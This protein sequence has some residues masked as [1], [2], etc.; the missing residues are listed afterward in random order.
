MSSFLYS[1]PSPALAQAQTVKSDY[2]LENLGLTNLHRTYW[3]LPAESLY[4][5]VIFRGEGK[6]TRHGPMAVN[7]GRHT[8]RSAND[9]FIVRE[10]SSEHN[11]WW[12]DYNRPFDG[13]KFS[14]LLGRMQAFLQGR[15][16]FVQDCYANADPQYRMPVRIV[17]DL[18]WHSLFAQHVHHADDYGGIPPARAGVHGAVCPVLQGHP[19]DRR[20]GDQHV[21]HYQL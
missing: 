14:A 5:E 19:P 12:G 1:V 10:A 17:T 4:E 6:L 11:V 16:V 2:G 13:Q 8:A 20:Y 3:N 9:K 15:E 21:H 7:T 18:A